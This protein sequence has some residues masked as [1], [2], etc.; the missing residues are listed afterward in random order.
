MPPASLRSHAARTR[1]RRVRWHN[2]YVRR[3]RSLIL[4]RGA[5]K[6]RSSRLSIPSNGLQDT[7]VY[8][9]RAV[10][11]WFVC[12]GYSAARIVTQPVLPQPPL[13]GARVGFVKQ[14]M[15]GAKLGRHI[16]V[17]G[18]EHPFFDGVIRRNSPITSV[19]PFDITAT[20]LS[21]DTGQQ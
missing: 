6:Q 4:L 9:A 14:V 12:T 16:A 17:H 7:L 8:A 3:N 20:A 13:F 18:H 10:S 21:V 15:K 2:E 1:F 11:C 5:T 19:Y